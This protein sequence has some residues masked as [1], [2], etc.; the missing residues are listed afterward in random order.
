MRIVGYVRESPVQGDTETAYAQKERIRRWCAQSGHQLISVCQDV[1]VAGTTAVRD[2]YR[3]LIDI[4]RSGHAEAVLVADL[5]VL[6]PDKVLQEIMIDDLRR[7]DVVVVATEP[8]DM[9]ALQEAD[10]DRARM[11]VRDVTSR[12]R[13]YLDAYGATGVGPS[14]VDLR[15][16][17]P[18]VVIELIPQTGSNAAQ[19]A[20]PTA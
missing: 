9:A 3:V 2:G 1:G 19:A 11:L 18:D 4:V 10:G 16:D 14:V 6:S 15:D 17:E 5:A 12:V 7:H 20:R 8:A 13:E